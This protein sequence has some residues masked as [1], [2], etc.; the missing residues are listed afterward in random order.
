MPYPPQYG[1]YYE[2]PGAEQ[3]N[4]Q[5]LAPGD[6]RS[7]A[8]FDRTELELLRPQL[9]AEISGGQKRI[10]IYS[11]IKYRGMFSTKIFES[12]FCYGWSPTRGTYMA[13]PYG[14][15]KYT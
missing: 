1:K 11:A 7:F 6:A 13:G 2:A 3:I 14:Y 5:W 4:V 8:S 12:R 15:N 10:Y 9:K